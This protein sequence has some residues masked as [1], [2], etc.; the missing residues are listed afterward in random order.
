[1]G[2]WVTAASAIFIAILAA[3]LAYWNSVRLGKQ[4][5]RIDRVNA[6]LSE[7]YGPL[8]AHSHVALN[9][10]LVFLRRYSANRPYVFRKG[11]EVSDETRDAWIAWMKTVFMPAN[12]AMVKLIV[13]K[14]HLL[15]GEDMPPEFHTFLA[16]VSGYEVVM[17]RWEQG[18][19]STYLSLIPHPGPKFHE[20][21]AETFARLKRRQQDLLGA[22]AG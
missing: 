4:Q 21:I 12:R 5:A 7:F 10:R 19:Y 6:Q 1:M 17:K 3:S 15:D 18:D 2:A 20:Y 9:A 11:E 16:H 8:L 22:H 14:T 13:E